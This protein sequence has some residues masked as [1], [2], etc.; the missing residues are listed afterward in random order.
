MTHNMRHRGARTAKIYTSTT[1]G[2]PRTAR[3]GHTRR[4]ASSREGRARILI[5]GR[6]LVRGSTISA[7]ADTW[8]MH[9]GPNIPLLGSCAPMPAHQDR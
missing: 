2:Q 9:G 1:A 3:T 6:H 4:N 8:S 7:K 5:I